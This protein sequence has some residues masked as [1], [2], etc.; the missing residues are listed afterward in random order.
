MSTHHVSGVQVALTPGTRVNTSP[1]TASSAVFAAFSRPR[2]ICVASMSDRTPSLAA[3]E[4]SAPA[5]DR[6]RYASVKPSG[7]MRGR[8]TSRITFGSIV[9]PE[10]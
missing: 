4:P 2:L 1:M 6:I 3:C 8:Y 7:P 5:H 10:A 9:K